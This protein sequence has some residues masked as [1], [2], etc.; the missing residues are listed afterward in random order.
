MMSGCSRTKRITCDHIGFFTLDA[1][2]LQRFY[3]DKLGFEL[4]DESL[5]DR[6]I[7]KTIFGMATDCRFIKLQR[8]GFMLE[9]F[10]P[11]SA[12]ARESIEC[13]AGL[14]HWGY[15]VDDRT[16]FVEKQKAN[17]IPVTEIERNGRTVY[18][19]ADPDGNRI[20][21]RDYPE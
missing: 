18:F 21:I 9:I 15:C 10:E 12:E 16:A 4:K 17:G 2:S 7:V 19:L 1:D 11:L 13:A 14:N 20:E 6:A 5:L 3:T 8:N